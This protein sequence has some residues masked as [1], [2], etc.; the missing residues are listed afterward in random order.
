MAVQLLFNFQWD[1]GPYDSLSQDVL[2]TASMLLPAVNRRMDDW[3]HLDDFHLAS[4]ETT[5]ADA[6]GGEGR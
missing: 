2:L 6:L 3:V 4:V 1:R 5:D